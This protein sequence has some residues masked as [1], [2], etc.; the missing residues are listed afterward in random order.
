[1]AKI[2]YSKCSDADFDRIL[3]DVVGDMS[4]LEILAFGDVNMILREELNNEVLDRW[5]QEQGFDEDDE[6]D[7]VEDLKFSSA[8]QALQH[9]ADITGKKIKIA[10]SNELLKIFMERDDMTEQEAKELIEELKERVADG[11]DP[12]EVLYDEGLEP[13][14]IFELI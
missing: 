14:Y 13:D 1:M 11:E 10:S 4:A 3:Q 12:E 6:D 5:A 8:N 7:E 9:F 2:D